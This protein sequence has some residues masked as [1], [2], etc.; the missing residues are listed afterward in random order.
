M[1]RQN[2]KGLD[3]HELEALMK[4]SGESSY[5]AK[6]IFSW[7]Y[8]KSVASF[9]EMTN[10]SKKTREDFAARW[11]I[12][13]LPIVRTERSE[14]CDTTKYLFQVTEKD[15]VE[16]VLM[17]FENRLS[18]CVST[19]AGCAYGCSFCAS[20]LMGWKRNLEAWEIADQFLQIQKTQKERI[21]NIVFMGMGEPLSNYD[22]VLKAIRILNHPLGPGIGI[23]HITVST[24]GLVPKIKQLA[25]EGLPI[26]LAISLHAPT[27]ALRE[28]LLPINKKYKIAELMEACRTYQSKIK[29]RMTFEY[30]LIGGINDSPS[31]AKALAK[32]L[33]GMRCHVNLIPLNPLPEYPH[34]APP[35]EAVRA[36]QAA[37]TAQR[38]PV[39]VRQ[40]RGQDI[41]AACGQLRRRFVEAA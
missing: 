37:L 13:S 26:R 35:A 32:L 5:R 25:N 15:A 41:S 17:V 39:S 36:F 16:T 21:S 19:Q 31:Q 34:K 4:S 10:L 18:L 33:K 1:M 14:E 38:I 3:Y 23:R 8:A 30:T 27:D 22:N 6:Q 28:T 12:L 40:E 2:I 11:Q 20:G 29:R 9:E 24:V 7:L